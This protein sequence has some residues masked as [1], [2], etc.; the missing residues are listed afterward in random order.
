MQTKPLLFV[1]AQPSSSPFHSRQRHSSDRVPAPV[2][3][4][5][6]LHHSGVTHVIRSPVN[7]I[8]QAHLDR[9]RERDRKLARPLPRAPGAAMLLPFHSKPQLITYSLLWRYHTR[10]APLHNVPAHKDGFH[11]PASCCRSMQCD[12][13]LLSLQAAACRLRSGSRG[14]IQCAH[15]SIE[16]VSQQPQ[17]CCLALSQRTMLALFDHLK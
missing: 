17:G 3:S 7:S 8:N 4:N 5:T 11:L 2:H 10:A 1:L 6:F 15:P 12:G 13:S 9:A 14:P 16:F